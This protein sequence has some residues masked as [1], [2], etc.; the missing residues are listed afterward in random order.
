MWA[1]LA[2][3]IFAAMSQERLEAS[4]DIDRRSAREI[5]QII[6]EQD[7][8]VAAA[9]AAEGD[10]IAHAV[11][12]I[13]DRLSHGGRLFYAGAGTS[14]RIAMLDA[15]ELP[16]TYGIDASLVSVIMAGGERAFFEAV[17]GAEDDEDAAIAAVNAA[18]K[19][20]DAV[21][22]IA[23]SG[24]TPYTVA[25]IR[26]ANML[27][28]LTVGITSNPNSPLASEA[29]IAIAPQ[30]GPEVIMGST[31]MKSGTAQ[32]LVLNTLSTGVMILLGRVHS[33]LMIDMP[34]TNE[35]LRS[36][37]VRMVELA[38]GVSRPVAVQAM[39][40]ANGNVKLASVMAGKRLSI[41][42]AKAVLASHGGNL[43]KV[44]ES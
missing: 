10:R 2:D 16:P 33:N 25:A 41:D 34:A 39:R 19:A 8:L 23:A 42:D 14:G 32:K 9:V 20:E 11:D 6:Q 28:A 24:T 21:V 5:V 29:D 38:V 4:L 43:R 17:E 31:R 12:Q 18:V 13:A 40:D 30:T 27:G 26:R 44:L 3:D 1:L 22:G 36:R 7:A 37:A 15:S 35:K